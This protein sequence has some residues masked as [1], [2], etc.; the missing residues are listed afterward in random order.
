LSGEKPIGVFDS[1][2]G[3]LTV[4]KTL[5]ERFPHEDFIYLGDT[6]RIPYGAKSPRTIARYL[7]QNIEYFKSQNVK[8]VVVACNSASSVIPDIS[9]DM[10]LYN[11]IEPGARAAAAVTKNFKIGVIGTKATVSRR[12]YVTQIEM[13]NSEIKVF[14]QACPLLVPLVEEGWEEDPITNL[15]VFRY[16]SPLQAVGIDTL[17]MGCTHYPILKNTFRKVLGSGVE[18]VDSGHALADT[19]E[20]DFQSQNLAANHSGKKG[21]LKI[22]TTDISDSFQFSAQRILSPHPVGAIELV[23]I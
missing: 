11:V 15:I 3:G 18:L 21:R 4:L 7:E 19:L 6:A 16:L 17:I 20:R 2:L 23:D 14:Q 9:T 1:G 8:A 10:K 5:H 22:L 13:L 12:S